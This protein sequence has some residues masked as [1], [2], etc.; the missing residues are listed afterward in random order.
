MKV[1]SELT[2]ERVLARLNAYNNP[3]EG[4]ESDYV[5]VNGKPITCRRCKRKR[6]VSET[7]EHLQFKTCNPCRVIER[8][9]KR[10]GSKHS[11]IKNREEYDMI[12]QIRNMDTDLET[13]TAADTPRTKSEQTRET[14]PDVPQSST[15][16]SP[17]QTDASGLEKDSLAEHD[18]PTQSPADSR[19]E[20]Q[21][22]LH[23]LRQGDQSNAIGE[24]NSRRPPSVCVCCGQNTNGLD[25]L[26]S[27][28]ENTDSVIKSLDYYLQL[29]KLNHEQELRNIVFTTNEP[30]AQLLARTA[31]KEKTPATVLLRLYEKYILA[32]SKATGYDFKYQT[33][34]EFSRKYCDPVQMRVREC[35]KCVNEIDMLFQNDDID[36]ELM[37]LQSSSVDQSPPKTPCH[38][39]IFVS[40]NA[41][42]G[43]LVISFTHQPHR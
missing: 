28:C 5:Y 10:R 33:E 26:C 25:D 6:L 18:T 11:V 29:L 7:P 31:A 20:L 12:Q 40:Y 4:S 41:R 43:R 3:N 36:S 24:Q 42:S 23:F 27:P 17:E 38:S 32:I 8:A 34:S 9:Q 21:Q 1:A 2:D 15:A 19:A 14:T 37:A 13:A 16:P 39:L 35:L 22:R 30:H